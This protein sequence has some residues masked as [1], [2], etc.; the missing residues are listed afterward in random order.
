MNDRLG[1]DAYQRLIELGDQC[2]AEKE[3][4]RYRAKLWILDA[5]RRELLG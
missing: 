3:L 4:K 2:K 5:Y 1:V